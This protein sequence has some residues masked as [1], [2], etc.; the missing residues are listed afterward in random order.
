MKPN[1]NP[2]DEKILKKLLN[3]DWRGIERDIETEQDFFELGMLKMH[4][5]IDADA[6]LTELGRKRYFEKLEEDK[7]KDAE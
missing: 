1:L 2:E 6:Q 5:F 7:K 3:F 4:G